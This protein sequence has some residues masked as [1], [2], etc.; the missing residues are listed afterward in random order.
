[1]ILRCVEFIQ[2]ALNQFSSDLLE[3]K[4]HAGIVKKL[5]RVQHIRN[6]TDS[7]DITPL[8][9]QLNRFV[10]ATIQMKEYNTGV[11]RSRQYLNNEINRIKSELAPYR[12]GGSTMI[13][14]TEDGETVELKFRKTTNP[15]ALTPQII[16]DCV[17]TW[18]RSGAPHEE[19]EEEELSR[20]DVIENLAEDLSM[21]IDRSRVG[22]SITPQ[23]HIDATQSNR[24]RRK[25]ASSQPV[26]KEATVLAE[27]YHHKKEQLKQLNVLAKKR[28]AEFDAEIQHCRKMI[29]EEFQA[30]RTQ[31]EVVE[32]DA[33]ETFLV[34]L[35]GA[36]G[37]KHKSNIKLQ[38]GPAHLVTAVT[39]CLVDLIPADVDG[40]AV[41]QHYELHRDE[42]VDSLV[43]AL[44]SAHPQKESTP[45]EPTANRLMP[46]L[47][48][49]KSATSS[50][51]TPKPP[52]AAA[53]EVA[54]DDV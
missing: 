7:D 51:A 20:K 52:D 40:K 35:E 38:C 23:V 24:K 9:A 10:N 53:E 46:R 1:M 15:R 12:A 43:E 37:R 14:A 2:N 22:V 3:K 34:R 16:E 18:R 39:N 54:E 44:I 8:Q 36:D 25:I 42:F 29:E 21:A 30:T 6:M 47:V 27:E 5:G 32:T 50:M 26:P 41:M 17:L 49:H 11:K 31:T 4:I 13:W 45:K 19:E 48:V 33:G 28:Q